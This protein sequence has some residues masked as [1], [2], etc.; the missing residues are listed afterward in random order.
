MKYWALLSI[1]LMVLLV[2]CIEEPIVDVWVDCPGGGSAETLEDCPEPTATPTLT[3]DQ[4]LPPQE[5]ID[6]CNDKTIDDACQFESQGVILSGV[7]DDKPGIFAC[8]PGREDNQNQTPN[9]EPNVNGDEPNV[10]TAEFE[11]CISNTEDAPECKDCCDCLDDADGNIRTACRDSCATND[12]SENSDFIT[13]SIP[14]TLGSDGDYSECVDTGSSTAC[15]SCCEGSMELQCGDYRHC[16]TA[17]NNEYGDS[18]GPDSSGGSNEPQYN[19]EQALSDRAQETTIAFSALA[20][21]TGDL[22]ADSFLPPGKVAD[23]SGFQYLRDNDPDE[24]GH[25]TD[26]VT[27]SGNN[28]LYIL[29]DAQLQMLETGVKDQTDLLNEFAYYRFPLMDAFRRQY[30]GDIPVGTSGLSKTAVVEYSAALFRKDGEISLRR[31]E[32]FGEIIR[33][34]DADQKKYLDAMVGQGMLSWPDIQDS[35]IGGQVSGNLRGYGSE[36]FAWY[37]G[38]IE[39]DSYFNPERNAMYFGAFYMKDAPAVGVAGYTISSTL[40]GNSGDAVFTILD[41]SQGELISELVVTQ[42]PA[43][44]AVVDARKAIATELRKLLT[45]E[46]IDEETVL[47]LAE[48]YGRLD[49]EISYYYAMNFAEVGKSL[50]DS[51]MTELIELRNLDEFPCSGAY[52][53]SDKIT[54]PEIENT[55]FLFE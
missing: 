52:L 53:Y 38:S 30:S 48:D 10:N 18:L 31:A 37:G 1:V 19:V 49:G 41:D 8:A 42:K 33:S 46:T 28:V 2:G 5:A 47:S 15:K 3:L 16:R 34:L 23:F 4:N 9:G 29:N 45:Q 40:T 27:I 6:A 43:L 20:Y 44:Y 22:C 12:F 25:N 35:D 39:A 11:S 51:Q 50:T 32:L 21:L 54:M 7:C 17:C 36:L 26:F 55:D 24:M 14:S 13:V